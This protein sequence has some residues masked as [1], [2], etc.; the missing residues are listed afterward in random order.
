[1]TLLQQECWELGGETSGHILCLDR[2]TTGDGIIAALQVLAA[3]V[4]S[5]KTLAHLRV[6]LDIYPQ[7]LINVRMPRRFDVK[8]SRDVQQAVR[9]VE[10]TL[11]GEGRVVLRPSGTE[12]VVRVMV[13][14]RDAVLVERLTRQL[15]DTVQRAAEAAA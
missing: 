8:A 9:D 12:P 2:H 15:A 4:V 5:G 11:A 14:G 10:R 3:V 13:E 6:G 1:M 7:K